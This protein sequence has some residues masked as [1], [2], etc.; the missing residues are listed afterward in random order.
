LNLINTCQP[1]MEE[2]GVD[3]DTVQ[4]RGDNDGIEGEGNLTH[5]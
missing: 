5:L 4:M 2:K 1:G 3:E